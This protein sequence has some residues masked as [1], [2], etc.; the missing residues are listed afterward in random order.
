MKVLTVLGT[1]P[2]II[3]LSRVIE[4]ARRLCEHVLVHT[5]QNF[6]PEPERHLLRASSGVRAARSL[7]RRHGETL[8]RAGRA[9]R[10]PRWTACCASERPDAAADP[11]RHQQRA[12]AASSPSA[13]A[14]RCYHMEAGNRCYDDRVPEEVNRRIIDHSS[15][16]LMPYTQRSK[17][18][19]LREGIAG[20][21]HLRDRQP[22]PRGARALRRRTSTPPTSSRGS[23]SRPGAT[24]WSTMH[25]A[26]NVDI[27]RPAAR[28]DGGPGA[29]A[30]RVRLPGRLQPAPAHAQKMQPVR[31]RRRATSRCA[32]SSP[33]LLRFR[34]ARARARSA[35]LSDSGTVQEECC[36]F[37]VPNVTIRD[38]TERPETIECGSNMLSGVDPETVLRCVRPSRAAP[39]AWTP[40]PEYLAPDVSS[41]VVKIVLGYLWAGRQS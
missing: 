40:P 5:G 25:R 35:S 9:H 2:E 38:V 1:R 21:A 7:P 12:R 22:D 34:R 6:D 4:Q 30:A 11:G 20:R 17:E 8:R 16:V 37:R 26:E 29:G 15:T 33:R 36:L 39:P 32:S 19:L 18:N 31:R 24:S 27:G 41:T 13:W 23:A 14:S 3:R 10:S 28:P